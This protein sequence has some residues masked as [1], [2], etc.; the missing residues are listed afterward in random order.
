MPNKII[1]LLVC[2]VLIIGGL[3]GYGYYLTTEIDALT[4]RQTEAGNMI[5]D[6]QG[7]IDSLNSDISALT[8]QTQQTAGLIDSLGDEIDSLGDEIDALG[9]QFD[10]LEAINIHTL[11]QQV[12]NGVVRILAEVSDG[13][14][15]GSGFVFDGQ[16]H[17]VTA[18]HVVENATRIDVIFSDGTFSRASITGYSAPSDIAVL[19]LDRISSSEPLATG[20]SDALDV[21]AAVMAI[22]T[23]FDMPGT[24]T[25]GIVSQ[26]DR[27]T[28]VGSDFS[29]PRGVT[30]LIQFDAA[31]NFGNSGGPLLNLQGKV[32]GVIVAR[33]DPTEGDGISYAV[34]SNKFQRVALAIID[35]GHFDYPWMGVLVTDLTPEAAQA[36]Q[37][38]TINGALVTEIT[39]GSPAELAGIRAEDIITAIDGI[40][41]RDT[42]GITSY[43]GENKSPGD[44]ITI[45]VLRNRS[46]LEIVV[47]LGILPS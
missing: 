41:A 18:Y 8:R 29:E 46:Q 45:T 11:Y 19:R 31:A 34:S 3:A 7:S 21:G 28:H 13:Q 42:A 32:I 22:G 17:V 23:P 37:L 2:L 1:A 27:F 20:D 35:H 33:V 16:G 14:T 9:S 15:T 38:D 10:D 44:S 39:A 6:L 36:R 40:A 5:A 30:N 25:M 26:K 4:D 24:V 12:E 47:E 43:L